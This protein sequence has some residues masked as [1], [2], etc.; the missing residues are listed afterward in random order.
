MSRSPEARNEEAALIAATTDLPV[1]LLLVIEVA[2]AVRLG[3]GLQQADEGR[4]RGTI[5]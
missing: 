1:T 3:E 2:G 5:R 4:G